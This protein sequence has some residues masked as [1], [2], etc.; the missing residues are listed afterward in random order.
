MVK[1]KL[2]LEVRI[3]KLE[4]QLK[5]SK[6]TVD[7]KERELKRER[8]KVSQLEQ[9]LEEVNVSPSYRFTQRLHSSP[10]FA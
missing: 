7:E 4:G 2:D 1:A 3:R 10:P 8:K 6:A 9:Q 5:E